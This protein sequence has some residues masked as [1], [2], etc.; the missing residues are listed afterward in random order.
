MIG[1]TM[2]FELREHGLFEDATENHLV[3]ARDQRVLDI[4]WKKY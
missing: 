4:V 1:T 3:F 2:E